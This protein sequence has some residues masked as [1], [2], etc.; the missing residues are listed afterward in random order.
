MFLRAPVARACALACLATLTTSAWAQTASAEA[1]ASLPTVVIKATAQTPETLPAAAPGG[2]IATG[3]RLG[4]LGNV[5]T[6]DAPFST[7]AYTAEGI[8]DLHATTVGAV[9]RRD[10]SVRTATN[11]G[12]VVENF[13]VRGFSVGAN[14]IA[15]NGVYGLAPEQNTPTEM[16]E[17]V[18]LIKGP[19][20]MVMGVPPTGDVGGAI[21]LV[22]KRAGEEPLTRLTTTLSSSSNVQVHADVARRL[23]EEKRLGVR[24]NALASGGETW[25]DEQTKSRR[26]GHVALDYQGD[27]GQ[28]EF[29]AYSLSNRVSKGVVMQP[30]LNGWSTVP[31][32]PSGDT[33]F[34]YGEDVFSNTDTQGVI[35]RGDQQI[36]PGLTLFGSLGAADHSYEGFIF[37]TRPVWS[38]DDAATGDATGTVYNSRGEYQSRTLE[39]GV[40]GLVQTGSVNHSLSLAANVLQYEGGGWGNGTSPIVSN[41]Y[42]PVPVTM[43]AAAASDTFTQY[44]DD[45]MSA[46]S[47]VDAMS[48]A[49]GKLQLIAGLRW[50][51]V[52]QKLAGYEESAVTPLLGVVVKPW[53]KHVSLYGNYAE[54]LS[55]GTTVSAPY[56]NEGETF[57][58]YKTEQLEFGVKWQSSGMTQTASLFQIS[59]PALIE[60]GNSQLL[61]GEQRNR[62][63][64]WTIAG[65]LSESLALWGGAAY[66]EAEQT[67]T[68]DGMNQGNSQIGV[69]KLT[70]N[71]GA[72]WTLPGAP[73]VVLTGRVNHTGSQWLTG[74]NSVKLPA[75]T[76][77][78]L[79]AR[80]SMRWG[81]LPVV[82]KAMVTNVADKAYF[83]G[84]WGA[85]RVN[86]GAPR[87]YSLAAQFDF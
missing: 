48:M 62:G 24:V 51:Q 78:D 44:N 85:G 45:V 49:D 69:P 3:S 33:N 80:Y 7:T 41:I 84:I 68:T 54:G 30:I 35:L 79:G 77:V 57:E 31:E 2:H 50:Q 19:S 63:I 39:A 29:D 82:L 1:E 25:L 67:K 76:T 60:V 26:I 74:D 53:G 28:I 59:K 21:N 36:A 22:P 46:L 75:W 17:R 6:M 56:D 5:D 66:T 15:I 9:L 86:V 23:G 55:A 18:E 72:D 73:A 37:G 52:E 42:N 38:A 70:M 14:A 32:A 64:E 11:E 83:E 40:R 12:H 4:V 65:P 43:P 10:P 81:N 71:L 58:P 27:D 13:V 47:V 20:A 8:A 61:D 87:T 16:F 34:F